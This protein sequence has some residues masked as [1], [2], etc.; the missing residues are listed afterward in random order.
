MLLF[1][2][3]RRHGTAALTYEKMRNCIMK[4]AMMKLVL[5][6]CFIVAGCS[7]AYANS[8]TGFQSG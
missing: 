4:N 5:A 6:W 3:W 7:A 8:I 2:Q 1:K